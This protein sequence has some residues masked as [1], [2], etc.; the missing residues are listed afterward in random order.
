VRA[1]CTPI[2]EIRHDFEKQAYNED[3]CGSRIEI[4]AISGISAGGNFSPYPNGAFGAGRG[5]P[6]GEAVR[7]DEDESAK[8]APADAPRNRSGE[9]L[10]EDELREVEE[11]KATDRKVRQHEQA[12]IAA[13]GNLVTSGASYQY[14][15]GPDGQRYAVAGEVGISTSPGRTPEE[16]VRIAA[17]IRAA[18]LA[19]ADPSPQDRKVA[20]QAA[21]M[22]MQ[23]ALEIALRSIAAEDGTQRQG[24]A[25]AENTA[26]GSRI[27]AYR[28]MAKAGDFPSGGF[29][30]RV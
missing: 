3:E 26:T 22:Q 6:V 13:G 18:A 8:S 29:S 4:M 16:T 11:L 20:A 10:S 15:T 14:V 1:D 19:P 7:E 24:E 2:P 30:V 27:D 12:H 23:A 21:R 9:T 5:A 25:A 17:R 28:A